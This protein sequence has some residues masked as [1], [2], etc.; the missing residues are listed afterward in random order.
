MPDGPPSKPPTITKPT[1]PDPPKPETVQSTTGGIYPVNLGYPER[2]R[3]SLARLDE[4]PSTPSAARA[5]LSGLYRHVNPRTSVDSLPRALRPHKTN[6]ERSDY[7]SKWD[8][9]LFHITNA[10][11]AMKQ[12]YAADAAL[13]KKA[14]QKDKDAVVELIRVMDE[15]IQYVEKLASHGPDE[16]AVDGSVKDGYR[17]MV[18]DEYKAQERARIKAEEEAADKAARRPPRVGVDAPPAVW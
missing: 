16:F 8:L 2:L 13:P 14:T 9:A 17:L 7:D 12:A 6:P 1:P 10:A 3:K 11:V 4:H 5:L 15:R 18:K